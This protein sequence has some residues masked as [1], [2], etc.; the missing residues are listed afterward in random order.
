MGD[1]TRLILDELLRYR[2][3]PDRATEGFKRMKHNDVLCPSLERQLNTFLDCSVKYHKVAYDVQGPRDRGTD[4]VLR[5][6]QDDETRYLVLQVKSY[7]DLKERN[8]LNILKAQLFEIE[9]EYGAALTHRFVVLCTDA[10]EH[11]NQLRNIKKDCSRSASIT[12]VDPTYAWTF[13]RLSDMRIDALVQAILK[14]DDA[15]YREARKSISDFTPLE[16]AILLCAILCARES[17]STRVDLSALRE[18]GFLDEA[19]ENIP[20]WE[21]D[22][23]FYRRDPDDYDDGD[24]YPDAVDGRRDSEVRLAEA[25]DALDDAVLRVSS[26][27]DSIDLDRP[28]CEALEATMLDAQVRFGYSGS[29]LVAYVFE[30]LD[31]ARTFELDLEVRPG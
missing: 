24:E 30:A 25:I 29:E 17:G 2:Q 26:S 1:F 11:K 31:V 12:V 3:S 20:D 27:S 8:Y 6:T 21:R 19:L 10:I 28:S 16:I 5:Y 18:V 9:S 13:L 15:V 7:D 14:E 23:F 22:E 4:I